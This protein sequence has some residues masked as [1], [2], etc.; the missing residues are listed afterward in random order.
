MI[1]YKG[2]KD[3][4]YCWL[5]TVRIVHDALQCID[6]T[7]PDINGGRAK[8][9]HGRVESISYL[10]LTFYSKLISCTLKLSV[11]LLDLVIK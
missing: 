9:G 6:S 11:I 2:T 10:T 8:I 3:L 4:D 5:V 1:S 7:N